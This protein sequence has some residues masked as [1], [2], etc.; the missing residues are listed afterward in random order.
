[1][2]KPTYDPGLTQQYTGRLRRT[3]NDDG[4]FNVDR[5]GG[6]WRH[7]HPY[8]FLLNLKWP[9]FIAGLFA[10]Y[11]VANLFFAILYWFFAQGELQ[12]NDAA[13]EWGR[14]LNDFF[15]SAHTLTTVGY[16]NIAP[17]GLAANVI[18]SVEALT[19]VLAFA[20]AT[21]LLFGRFSRP[22][23]RIAFSRNVLVTPYADAMSLQFRIVNLR[24]NVLMELE[25]RVLLMTVERG[26]GSLRRVYKPLNLERPAVQFLPLTWTIVHPIDEESPFR[27]MS[28][29]QM[30]GM[31]A[32]L[33]ILIRAWDDTFSQT[34][35]ARHSYA[36]DEFAW[37]ARFA[38][39]FHVNEDGALVLDVDKVGD[40]KAPAEASRIE[41][42]L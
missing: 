13:T 14:F 32:E 8:L 35:H 17:H 12:G 41:Q 39:A 9:I 22:S 26:D 33:L 36:Y 37:N 7:L 30:A 27:D 15:F 5:R 18:S 2:Q 19:G 42:P 40:L 24:P 3:I 31:E 34:V 10:A 29:E 16:G 6:S 23:A 21:G 1:M 4:S 38:P 20:I 11:F 28:K 25:A